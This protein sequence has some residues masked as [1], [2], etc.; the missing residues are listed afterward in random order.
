MDRSSQ[1][2]TLNRWHALKTERSSW[3]THYR[4]LSRYLMPRTGRFLL[5]D[6]NR[7]ERRHNDIYDNTGTRAVGVLGAGMMAG[8][9][10]PARPW[11]RLATSDRALNKHAPVK[12]WLND[13]TQLMREVFARS[14]TYRSLH[15]G[16]EE[17][18]VYG[19]SAKI[20]V[21]DFDSVI[22]HHGL[23][24]GEYAI[25]TNYRGEVDTIFREF[26]KT[27][28]EVVQEFGLD[29]VSNTVRS[30]YE[31]GSYDQWVTLIHA[32]EPRPVRDMSR[33]DGANMPWRSVYFEA[34]S[35]NKP[36]RDSGFTRFPGLVSRWTVS[37]GDV[38]GN[39]PGM[40]ALG[41]VKQ[42]QLENL[43]KAQ[44]IDYMTK[45]PLQAPSALKNHLVD[46]LPGGVSYVDA[47]HPQ[48]GIRPAWEVRLDLNHLLAD[49]LDVR[50]RINAAFYVDLFLM[51]ANSQ[52]PQMTATEVAE[53][54]E[55]KL[56]MLGPTIERQHNE[57]LQPL[58]DGTFARMVEAGI[59]PPPPEELQGHELRVEYISMLAQ[60]QRAVATSAV[61]RFVGSLGVVAGI[62]PDVVDKFDADRWADEYSD[63]LGV[64]PSLIVSG[65]QVVIVRQQRAAQQQAMTQSAMANQAADTAA[66]LGGASTQ[67]GNA[68]TDVMQGLTGYSTPA[69]V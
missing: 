67:G 3:V 9:T 40:L 38:Y 7:G 69:A 28:H 8:M 10:S 66:K 20:L 53:R 56:I 22:H 30:L 65:E 36:L 47:A 68:L 24:A 21:D 14:N 13:V 23:T 35:P 57:E 26:D 49:I 2:R 44:G 55:E 64:D 37:G 6:R 5:Q 32:I 61:D 16:Y 43:R 17:L 60:A 12:L 42:L 54:H 50:G 52:N 62:K 33:R 58:I 48:A 59:V 1:D 51:L 29:A 45:P 31:R 25:A 15:A 39:S 41:D 19:T 4:E 63:M 46:M 27:V 34:G 18:A 11:F